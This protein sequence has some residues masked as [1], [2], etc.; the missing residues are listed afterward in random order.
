M[1]SDLENVQAFNTILESNTG[2]VVLKLG[3]TWCGPCKIIADQA[4]T[5]M[6]NLCNEYPDKAVCCDIDVDEC[7][8]LYALLKSKKRVSGIPAFLCW[9]KGNVTSIPDDTLIGANANELNLF[10]AR[11]VKFL[12]TA[13]RS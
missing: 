5:L 4:H 7:F 10:F 3:A 1:I 6:N 2:V 13:D 9:Y 8:E 12:S 11:C